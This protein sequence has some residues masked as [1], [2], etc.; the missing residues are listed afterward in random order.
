MKFWN[1]LQLPKVWSWIK[2]IFEHEK[3]GYITQGLRPKK[4]WQTF[5]CIYWLN[6]GWNKW[7]EGGIR[8]YFFVFVWEIYGNP[9][10]KMSVVE[11]VGG[12]TFIERK[13][14]RFKKWSVKE[15]PIPASCFW[16]D[17]S[18]KRLGRVN[19]L[20]LPVVFQKMYL[21][22]RGEALFFCDF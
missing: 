10:T 13:R 8:N 6:L 14:S 4:R 2:R 5:R 17:I 21:L 11:I 19:L 22:E 7:R 3:F 12:L 16:N 20:P 15:R 9:K 18:L 1:G